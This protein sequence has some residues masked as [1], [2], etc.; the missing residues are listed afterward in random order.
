MSLFAIAFVSGTLTGCG[1]DPEACVA[2]SRGCACGERTECE[3]GLV[4]EAR[5]C[6]SEEAEGK[7]AGGSVGAPDG[8]AGNSSGGADELAEGSNG[9]DGGAG[10][11]DSPDPGD[12]LGGAPGSGGA[13]QP[14]SGGTFGTGGASNG[15]N[16]SG[17]NAG[18]SSGG[19][20]NDGSAGDS[21]GGSGSGGSGGEVTQFPGSCFGCYVEFGCASQHIACVADSVCGAC[22]SDGYEKAACEAN[23][24][25][26]ALM[27]CACTGFCEA[28]CADVCI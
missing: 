14:G 16:G 17:G 20:S 6:V 10:S 27:A 1:E 18:D 4:C 3:D 15:G 21:S 25:F 5:I 11:G 26:Q 8:A 19:S 12:G 9:E 7:G 13:A 22:V 23:A 28:M 2:G 24:A